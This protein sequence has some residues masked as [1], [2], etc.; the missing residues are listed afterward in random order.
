[1]ADIQFPS[2]MPVLQLQRM[3][4]QNALLA[5][6]EK[7]LQQQQDEE[8]AAQAN[9]GPALQGDKAALAKLPPRMALQLAPLLD[10]LDQNQRNKL[11]E[12]ADWTTQAA[13]GVL[14]APADQRAAAYRAAIDEGTAR[15]YDMS[16][17]PAEYTPAI[18]GL[19][20]YHVARA[21]PVAEYF[22]RQAEMPTPMGP[23]GTPPGGAP[24]GTSS[25]Y[26]PS[27]FMAGRVQRGDDPLTAAAWAGSVHDESGFNPTAFNPKDPNGGSVGLIQWNG[28]RAAGLRQFAAAKGANPADPNVQQDYLQS[29]IDANP[30][31]K[32]ALAAAP[33]VADKTALITSQFIRPADTAGATARRTQL[34]QQYA[35]NVPSGAPP[36]A[37]G[38][39]VPAGA[40]SG[41]PQLSPEAMDLHSQISRMFPGQTVQLLGVQ[42]S[43]AYDKGGRA[44]IL[45]NG[46]RTSVEVPKLEQTKPMPLGNTG[47]VFDPTTRTATDL[48]FG[49]SVKFGPNGPEV[50]G[51]VPQLGDGL[52]SIPQGD[53]TGNAPGVFN[54]PRNEQY[55]QTL[56]P[57]MQPF[58]KAYA[59]GRMPVPTQAAMRNPAVMQILEA[60]H[61]YD[62]SFDA[63]NYQARVQ[64]R[65]TLTGGKDF[66]NIIAPANKFLNHAASLT[67]ATDAL[68]LGD[69][70]VARNG[71][72][73]AKLFSMDR[74]G[75]PDERAN[76][77]SWN[78]KKEAVKEEFTKFMGGSGRLTDAGRKA[79][80]DL[81]SAVTPSQIAG[82]LGAM[83]ELMHG[84]LDPY[85]EQAK[86]VLGNTNAMPDDLLNANSRQALAKVQAWDQKIR[87]GG[88]SA[89]TQAPAAPSVP[90]APAASAAPATPSA[91]AAPTTGAQG[92]RLSPQDAAKLPSGT[93]FIGMDGVP[94]VRK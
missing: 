81:D 25:A 48:M 94:R 19:L 32:A 82:A 44:L 31:F 7:R 59:E 56:P 66:D 61:N 38:G 3:D 30:Q 16:R 71:G 35:Q 69:S 78:T 85:V 49:R 13:L 64:L 21:E 53:A 29:E 18:D 73:Q 46:Q 72:N 54:T 4:A 43:P 26:T 17:L 76:L 24:A 36:V 12:T 87:S 40:P 58:V 75:T 68:G 9:V 79:N 47:L 50:T 22:K 33:T 6:Q 10:R 80:A 37:Q 62:P 45:L 5:A 77:T 1:M 91:P 2:L 11:K 84:Q 57:T 74:F 28:P 60:T 15:G 86:T 20:K 65:K 88:Q 8:T 34:A 90:A 39:S 52:P 14:G 93:P 63:S 89:G 83:T 41:T 92:P 27:A 42:G 67:D 55:L 23:P 70:T 51:G